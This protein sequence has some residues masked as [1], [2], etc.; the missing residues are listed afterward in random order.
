MSKKIL[1]EKRSLLNNYIFNTLYTILNAVYPLITVTYISRILFAEGVG[2]VS[3]A[4]NIASYFVVIAQLGIPKYGAREIAKKGNQ[5]EDRNQF[6]WEIFSINAVSTCSMIFLY[7]TFINMSTY[8]AD[9]RSLMN[10]MGL[11]IVFN[12][13]NVDWFYTGLEEFKYIAMRSF[14]VKLVALVLTFLFVNNQKDTFTYALILCGALGGNHIFNIINIRKYVHIKHSAINWRR[15]I[16]SIVILLA[17]NLAV[18][19][20][21]QLDTTMLGFLCGN[22]YVGYYTNPMKLVKLIVNLTTSVSV[23]L[24]PRLSLYFEL[25]YKDDVTRI[26]NKTLEILITLAAPCAVGLI[27]LADGV[28]SVFFGSSFESSVLTLRI[29]S[30]IIPILAVG[31][32]FGTQ[33]LIVV[34]KEKEL[35]VSVVCGAVTNVILN[36]FLIVRIQQNGAS[37]ASVIAELLVMIIQVYYSKKYI[38]VQLKFKLVLQVIVGCAGITLV[39]LLNML[40]INAVVRLL[41]QVFFGGFIYIGIEIALKNSAII[42][43]KNRISNIIKKQKQ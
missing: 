43:A 15:H 26:V 25:G 11:T 38:E 36:S 12:L 8:F 4:Q 32:L 27:I 41:G 37:I 22:R 17:M 39:S 31:N 30:L 3:Y 34:N 20:Y 23:I 10:V 5:L 6:F 42:F 18:E 9:T 35:L 21:V 28:V 33:V 29:L 2:E 16:K 19:L 14:V 24:L 40:A 7:Y 13:I 1:R